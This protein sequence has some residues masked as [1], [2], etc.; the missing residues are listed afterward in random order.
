MLSKLKIKLDVNSKDIR[1][2]SGSLFQGFLMENIEGDYAKDLHN[3]KIN[4]Y[5][6][7]INVTKEETTWNISAISREA[8]EKIISPILDLDEIIIKDKNLKIKI[9]DKSINIIKRE[10]FIE[11]NL[12][13]IFDSREINFKFLT[14]TA[15]KRDNRYLFIPEPTL[16]FQNLI[17]KFDSSGEEEIFS[18][19]LLEEFLQH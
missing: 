15:F 7:Y 3:L 13:E 5:S 10:D 8:Y 16:I 11:K 2:N 19:D 18:Y 17:R 14:P 9:L 12:F 6:Q 4:P 1:F